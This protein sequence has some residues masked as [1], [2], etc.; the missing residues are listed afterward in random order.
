VSLDTDIASF[1]GDEFTVTATLTHGT[2]VTTISVIYDRAGAVNVVGEIEVRNAAPTARC[3]TT[4][5]STAA[6]G[7]TLAISGTTYYIMDIEPINTEETVLH[8]SL[9]P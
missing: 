4:D 3:K 6:K 2:T 7:D 8:L 1:Y 5:V 9:N